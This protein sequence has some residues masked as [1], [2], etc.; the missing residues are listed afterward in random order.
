M[1]L[2]VAYLVITRCIGLAAVAWEYEP[3]W[4]R[5]DSNADFV[6]MLCLGFEVFACLLM[7]LGPPIYIIIKT[8]EVISTTHKK[9]HRW[10]KRRRDHREL[11]GDTSIN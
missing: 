1:T 11:L 3:Y 4:W 10:K 9:L 5:Q 8:S 6:L 7:I 2:I